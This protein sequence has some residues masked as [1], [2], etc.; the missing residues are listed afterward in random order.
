MI[1]KVFIGVCEEITKKTIIDGLLSINP[2]IEII[3]GTTDDDIFYHLKS[4]EESVVIFDKYFL[5]Y[6][7][8]FK[9]RSLKVINSKLRIYF[10]ELGNCSRFFGLRVYDT[11]ANG[12]IANI[13]QKEEFK[14]KLNLVL[15]GI[16]CYPEE[17]LD[18]IKNN[19]HLL[20]RKSC[21]EITEREMEVGLYLGQGKSIKEICDLTNNAAGTVSTHICRL[22]RKIGYKT[23]NDFKLLNNQLIKINVRSWSC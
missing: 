5:S 1:K 19:E 16:R 4:A 7:L 17:V 23:M 13:E 8:K 15:E 3:D 9:L 21:S 6:V 22:K 14:E 10:C 12:F 20:E 18:G 11:G 2:K